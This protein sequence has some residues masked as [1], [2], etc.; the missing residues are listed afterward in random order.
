MMLK[1]FKE[2]GR[3]YKN[4]HNDVI[5]RDDVVDVKISNRRSFRNAVHIYIIY[6]I[7]NIYI[8]YIYIYILH[9]PLKD[10]T[11]THK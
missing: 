9:S 4:Q 1:D 11:K 2:R 5:I 6:Y 8:I 10:Y 7:Y 3:A